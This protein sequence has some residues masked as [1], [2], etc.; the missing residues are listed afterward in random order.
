MS[1][2]MRKKKLNTRIEM[3]L[4]EVLEE[5]EHTETRLEFLASREKELTEQGLC[6]HGHTESVN[7]KTFCMSC[8]ASY[9]H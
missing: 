2:L 4:R 5:K 7:G 8:G 6:E 9:L 3:A 1:H